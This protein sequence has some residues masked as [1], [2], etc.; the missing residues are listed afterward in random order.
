MPYGQGYP[1]PNEMTCALRTTGDTLAYVSSV[2][3]IVRH[4]D[5]RMAVSDV[6]TETGEINHY[7]H[8]EIVLADLCSAFAM[9]ALTISCA[10]HF[11]RPTCLRARHLASTP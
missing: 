6:R 4:T 8:Q 7:I 3:D 2:R 10:P 5:G 1:Q 11:W 9:L